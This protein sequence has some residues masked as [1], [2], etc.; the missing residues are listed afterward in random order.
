[1]VEYAVIRNGNIEC[2]TK[3]IVQARKEA[4]R[5]NKYRTTIKIYKLVERVQIG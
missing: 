5:Y 4:K 1:M 2:T 3:S